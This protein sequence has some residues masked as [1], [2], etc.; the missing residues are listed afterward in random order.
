[1]FNISFVIKGFWILLRWNHYSLRYFEDN[2]MKESEKKNKIIK[3]CLITYSIGIIPSFIIVYPDLQRDPT[4]IL[5]GLL[6][7]AAALSALIIPSMT[8]YFSTIH[9]KF[10]NPQSEKSYNAQWVLILITLMVSVICLWIYAAV[11]FWDFS[12]IEEFFMKIK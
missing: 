3:L 5:L 1:M 6:G 2:F 12:I 7:P 8:I 11:Y 10:E 4:L 9:K